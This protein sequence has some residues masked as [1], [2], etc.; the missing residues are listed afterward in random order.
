[1]WNGSQG[2]QV[3]FMPVKFVKISFVKNMRIFPIFHCISRQ[4]VI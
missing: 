2:G 1:M 3:K 4:K